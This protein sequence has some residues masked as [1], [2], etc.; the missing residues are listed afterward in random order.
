M[1]AK[2]AWALL[3]AGI[4]A[5]EFVCEDGELMSE[6]V[7]RALKTHPVSTRLAIAVVAFHLGNVLPARVDPLHLAFTGIRKVRRR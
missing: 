6:G 1:N 2:Q 7:D 5:Y 4:L 3:A